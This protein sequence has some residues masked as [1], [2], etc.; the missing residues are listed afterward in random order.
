[1]GLSSVAATTKNQAGF[2]L[3][4]LNFI[5]HLPFFGCYSF[6][7]CISQAYLT[8][9]A[10]SP[11]LIE[12]SDTEKQFISAKS[13]TQLLPLPALSD[14]SSRDLSVVIPAYNETK[15]L[16]PML[17][18]AVD[19]LTANLSRS[20]EI[21]IV[22]DGSTDATVSLALSLA[23][24]HSACDIRVVKLDKN[25]GKGGAVRHGFL[26][27]R[28]GRILMVDADGAS[29]FEDLE[30]LWKAADD[31][32]KAGRS[33]AIGSRAHMVATEAVVK[34]GFVSVHISHHLFF[35]ALS[36]TKFPH[37]WFS[38]YFA[39]ARCWTHS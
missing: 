12:P 18:A 8:L 16:T 24:K 14:P 11:R 13:P 15:R 25:V 33:I 36:Y 9:V 17:Q 22:D 37:A 34:V 1:L 21:L 19:H 6:I 29:Q 5:T 35:V 23:H 3:R 30:L 7:S 2:V 28:G 27:A 10:I 20:F 32:E 31:I 39:D 4:I 38:L 26:H